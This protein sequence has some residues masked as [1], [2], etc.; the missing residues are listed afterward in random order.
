[1]GCVVESLNIHP[2]AYVLGIFRQGAHR[3]I[4]IDSLIE[5]YLEYYNRFNYYTYNYD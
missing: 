3:F 1:M 2:L 5:L 4:L